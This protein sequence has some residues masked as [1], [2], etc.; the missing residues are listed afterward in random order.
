MSQPQGDTLKNLKIRQQS[1]KLAFDRQGIIV[2]RDGYG[3][4]NA[5]TWR[6]IMRKLAS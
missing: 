6:T 1:V 4:G 5:E 2:Y 3:Q